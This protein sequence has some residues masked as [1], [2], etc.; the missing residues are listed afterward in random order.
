[1]KYAYAA[2]FQKNEDGSHSVSYPDLPSCSARGDSLETARENAKLALTKYIGDLRS[3]RKN[4][5]KASSL[6]NI[7]V[8]PDKF[9]G[10]ISIE[11]T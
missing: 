11:I 4:I 7:K 6:Y 9:V 5:P 1:M 8:G 2:V 10:L 3:Q